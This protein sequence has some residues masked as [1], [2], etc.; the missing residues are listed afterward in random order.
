MEKCRI[1]NRNPSV[2]PVRLEPWG[3]SYEV[4]E[5]AYLSIH[6]SGDEGMTEVE[7]H[8]DLI[9]IWFN[10]PEIDEEETRVIERTK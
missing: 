7:H 6:T 3:T 2:L 1:Y 4:P 5:G 10:G 9:I 8:A